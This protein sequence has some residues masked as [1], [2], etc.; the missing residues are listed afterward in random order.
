MKRIELIEQLNSV[1]YNIELVEK[2]AN[3]K[4]ENNIYYKIFG[5][6]K[7]FYHNKE[8]QTKALAYWKRRFDRILKELAYEK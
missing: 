7:E 8:I 6:E 1:Q 4:L 2:Y 5:S 3:Q